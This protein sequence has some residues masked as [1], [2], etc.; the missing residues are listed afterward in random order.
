M[1]RAVFFDFDGTFVESLSYHLAAWEEVLLSQHGFHLNPMTVK[2]NEGRPG[3]EIARAIFEQ[4][5]LPF[6]EDLLQQSITL[7]NERFRATHH[8]RIF[9]ENLQII[10]LLKKR[11]VFVG[12]VTGT[13]R[14]NLGVIVPQKVLRLFDVIITDGDTLLG[15][16]APDPYLAA[17]EKLGIQPAECLVVENAP[18]GIQSAKAAGMFCVALTTTLAEEH[19]QQADVT[20]HNHRRL[21][22]KLERDFLA[23]TFERK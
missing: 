7:K 6:S 13:K 9:P 22:Q 5:G 23:A 16:P 21:Y 1:I 19:L 20:L 17:A 8:A 14:A 11:G 12:L 4:A 15:K 18:L 2:L 3:L 10:D